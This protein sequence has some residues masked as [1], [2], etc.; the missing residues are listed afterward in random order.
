MIPD[1]A[2]PLVVKSC[3]GSIVDICIV[4]W[5]LVGV[6][7]AE[8]DRVARRE[9]DIGSRDFYELRLVEELFVE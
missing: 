2:S 4:T 9:Q 3:G 8:Q 5:V 6:V 7:Y 1:R